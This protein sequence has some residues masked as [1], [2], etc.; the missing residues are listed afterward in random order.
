MKIINYLQSSKIFIY[1]IGGEGGT[2]SVDSE[3]WT[4]V[5]HPSNEDLS[6]G[7]PVRNCVRL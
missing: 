1:F 2:S 7:T 5:N 3:R 6:L 4:V